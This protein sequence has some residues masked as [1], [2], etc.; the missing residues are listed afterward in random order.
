MEEVR[1]RFQSSRI[2][3]P[4]QRPA[5][6]SPTAFPGGDLTIASAESVKAKPLFPDMRRDEY[7]SAK[8][9]IS[10][11]ETATIGDYW[12]V[13]SAAA[14][15]EPFRSHQPIN[16]RGNY[17][18][19]Q[20]ES[21]GRR[22]DREYEDRE[23]ENRARIDHVLERRARERIPDQRS[24][25]RT[26]GRP[27]ARVNFDEYEEQTMQYDEDNDLRS[28]SRTQGRPAAR[29]NFDDYEVPKT[30]YD[31][32]ND[33]RSKSRTQGRSAAR[34]NFDEYEV[35]KTQ[36]DEDNDLRSKSRTQGRPAARFNFDE[37]E[38]PKTQY[39]EDY[40]DRRSERHA[41]RQSERFHH[42]EK[43]Q[44]HDDRRPQHLHP[45]EGDYGPPRRGQL[46]PL[47]DDRPIPPTNLDQRRD[48]FAPRSPRAHPPPTRTER[49]PRSERG[50]D[51]DYRRRATSPTRTDYAGYHGNERAA[52]P[53]RTD[54]AGYH[55]NGRAASPTRTD[56]A[57]YH[58]NEHDAYE[59]L[60]PGGRGRAKSPVRAKPPVDWRGSPRI[61]E[62]RN[63]RLHFHGIGSDDEGEP[64][65]R[66]SPSR[67]RA[68]SRERENVSRSQHNV[69]ETGSDDEDE[70]IRARS[71]NRRR[72]SS[73]E[74]ENANRSQYNFNET[75]SDEEDEPI[76]GR[77][78][79]RRRA[80]SREREQVSRKQVS[81]SQYKPYETVSKGR[82][83]VSISEDDY[84]ERPK[85][86]VRNYQEDDDD[87]DESDVPYQVQP[88]RRRS[89]SRERK[90]VR[91][92]H[93]DDDDEDESDVPYQ[94]QPQRRR[95]RS[96]ERKEP[97]EFVIDK[98]REKKEPLEFVIDV[99]Q[100]FEDREVTF[101]PS[102]EVPRT[103]S[104][105]SSSQ[106]SQEHFKRIADANLMKEQSEARH[107]ILKEVRQAMEMRDLAND[108]A[109]RQFWDRQVNTLNASLQRLWDNHIPGNDLGSGSEYGHPS[110]LTDAVAAKQHTAPAPVNNYATVK[111]QAPENLPAPVNNFTTVKV[112]APDN[113]PAGHKFSI[114]VNGK[115][116]TAQVPSGGVRKGDVFTIRIPLN[117]PP[118]P[119]AAPSTTIKVRAPAAL[120]EGYRFT[121]K[122][123]DRTIVATVPPGGV[124]KGEIFAVP[125][126]N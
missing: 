1:Q 3:P 47:E 78:P 76:R 97:L 24:K 114:R 48:R 112:Q 125:V 91:N 19:R 82:G 30:Q 123:G 26:Q 51:L 66:R 110:N 108:V 113:L 49:G 2:P 16:N 95:S 71:P 27:A 106:V 41:E 120:P 72:T 15:E 32:D 53:T 96:R 100:N 70:P 102:T 118:T 111:L 99:S 58:G 104:V 38:V 42:R 40:G 98:S 73:R 62:E 12:S 61:S 13:S 64:I 37:Y 75:G 109:D 39:D 18:R 28:K 65:R 33:L 17:D 4:E 87:E 68:S 69:N 119:V 88:Q 23:H 105:S 84:R 25:S 63:N 34:F 54:Y 21:N 8:S 77:S 57:G 29:F 107:Q 67:R 14:S 81:R 122:M 83:A 80:S 9:T 6:L 93:E 60:V 22:E 124:Q 79:S 85:S 10:T 94:V 117:A 46:D 74:R 92:Y 7:M 31:E 121:A 116:M 5:P 101:S 43:K 36:Y 86:R 20:Y 55:G 59:R 103:S 89:R 35:P 52:S 126:H 11:K 115:A 56:Y 45:S 44:H 50:V 90:G